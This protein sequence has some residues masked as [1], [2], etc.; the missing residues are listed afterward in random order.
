YLAVGAKLIDATV[1]HPIKP[2]AA[3]LTARRPDFR[4][5]LAAPDR[6]PILDRNGTILAVSL[7]GAALFADPKQIS[8]PRRDAATLEQALPML[9]KRA[10]AHRL[11]L[12]RYGFVYLD[13]DLTAAQEL[14][15]NRLGIP[16]LYFQHVWMR[17]YP[18]GDLAAHILGG[19]TPDQR[20]IAGVEEYF[21]R[22]LI[23]RPSKP[24]RLSIDIRVEDIVHREV[25][26]A[27]R[28]YQARGACG[29]VESMTG[30]IVA[31]VSLPDYDANDLHDA[32]TDSLFDRCISGD[33]EPGS[34]MKL[35]TMPAALQSGLIHYWDRF[36][37]THPL[38]VDGFSVTDYEP[39]H[40]WLAM[41]AVLAFSSNIGASRI[42]TIL[43]P[44]IQRAWL[45][46]MGFFK[47]SPVQMP[48]VQPPIWHPKDTWKLL[49]TMTVSFGN[50]IAM[51]PIILVNAVV[52]D[53]NGGILF[54]P[55]LLARRI[56]A[57][58]RRGVRV[59]R[60]SV[61]VIM[62]KLMRGVVLSGTGIYA[63][64][65]GYLVGGKTG[66]SQVVA[67]DGR[68]RN[69]LNNASF[70]AVFPAD[71]PHYVI[72]V[73][74]VHPKPTKKMQHFSYGFTTG[75]YVAAPAVGRIIARIGPMLGVTPLQGGT[76]TAMNARF[77]IP[78]KP[79]V[80]VG[81]SALGPGHPFP[82]GANRYAY[83]LA[84]RAPPK[85]PD[86]AAA[87]TALRRVKMAIPGQTIPRDAR[88]RPDDPMRIEAS[89]GGHARI[90][91]R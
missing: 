62:R 36:D 53:V 50:G 89:R 37:T 69:H 33:Y 91:R 9:D 46:K 18:E 7:P 12:K 81:R 90:A 74:V 70:M 40:D 4:T 58:P 24:L 78:L 66:T 1:L 3:V 61:S 52:A 68:Y 54:K 80:P 39:V 79:P 22:R 29:I 41:P 31:M 73:L 28:D 82:A 23:G 55:T 67:A 87:R 45:R 59:M 34:V 16:G 60:R 8:H 49:T 48:G 65:P 5:R 75:G 83:I 27:M 21:D 63:R 2:S 19:V 43:G 10:I 20:G 77:G 30:R 17:H 26:R 88:S 42:A 72:Y 47:P 64:V 44:E 85:H 11:S 76:L 38:F 15:V 71:H 35:M 86:R 14:A 32:P 51:A 84:N 57:P 56:G 25:A 6:A 13:R